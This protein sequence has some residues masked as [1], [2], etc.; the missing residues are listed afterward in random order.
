MLIAGVIVTLQMR[1]RSGRRDPTLHQASRGDA[2][3]VSLAEC[4]LRNC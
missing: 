4:Q 2:P 3:D 1:P